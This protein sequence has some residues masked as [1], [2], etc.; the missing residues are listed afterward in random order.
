VAVIVPNELAFG[1]ARMW[2]MLVDL[3]EDPAFTINVCHTR[4]EGIEWI[5]RQ[6]GKPA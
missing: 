3:A 5:Q 2:R 1:M 6:L 4:A